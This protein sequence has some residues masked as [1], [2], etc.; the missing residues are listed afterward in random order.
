MFGLKARNRIYGGIQLQRHKTA[1]TRMPIQPAFIPQKL[2][3]PLQQHIG[4]IATPSVKVGDYCLKGQTIAQANGHVSAA[5][6]AT[7]SGTVVEIGEHAV[8]HPS[9]LP[10]RCIVIETDGLDA[11]VAPIKRS[12]NH[13]TNLSASELRQKIRAAG[14][15]GLGGAGFP[16]HIKLDPGPKIEVETLI[17]NGAEC[18]PFITCDEMLMR[19]Q[20]Q[21]IIHGALYMRE[22]IHAQQCII[23]VEDSLTEAIQALRL[24][25]SELNQESALKVVAV[26]TKYPA[27]GE[28]QLIQALTGKEVPSQ[29]LPLDI[30]VVCHNVGTAAAVYDCLEHDQALISRIV[31]LTGDGI[32]QPQ[33]IEVRIGTP[34]DALIEH[35]GGYLDG[36]EQLIMGG[37]MM[38]FALSHDQLPIV[39]TTNCLLVSREQL[40]KHDQPSLPCIRCGACAEVCPIRLLPQQLYWYARAKDFDKAQDYHLFDCIECGCCA[41]VCPS[42]L[43][44]VQ[45]YRFAKNEIWAQEKE[46]QK[47]DQARQRHEFRQLRIERQKAEKAA[48]L[49]QKKAALSKSKQASQDP[50]KELIQAALERAQRKQQ[51]RQVKPK[52]TIDLSAEQQASIAAVDARRAQPS[53][54]TAKKDSAP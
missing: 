38:G 32:A 51:Q 46:R 6:H 52:N 50:K 14:I 23:G 37:P 33:N 10:A 18:E 24:T 42:Q 20:P 22:A 3:L 47:S 4:E 44:L 11:S 19:E 5:V 12:A 27:G 17:I 2:I 8:P 39:K 13:Q 9:G 25:V 54:H 28:K 34:I 48:R 31:T 16:A 49:Q 30:G 1:S 45:Y 53:S 41:Y 40:I 29:G 7:S 35:C 26:P 36:V 21:K 43:P 15:V